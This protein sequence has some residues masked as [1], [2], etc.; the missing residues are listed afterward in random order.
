MHTKLLY[1]H[2]G[3]PRFHLLVPVT[4]QHIHEQRVRHIELLGG[5]CS[6]QQLQNAPE[7]IPP[8]CVQASTQG[9]ENACK[10]AQVNC[11]LVSATLVRED[12]TTYICKQHL[13][14]QV[15]S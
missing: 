3:F 7:S 14:L 1:L 12:C 15:D 10:S 4:A 5:L 2:Q 13:K 8:G 6:V 11:V 9:D